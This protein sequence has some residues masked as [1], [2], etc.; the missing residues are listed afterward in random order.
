MNKWEYLGVEDLSQC[1]ELNLGFQVSS[2]DFSF[3]HGEGT[4]GVAPGYSQT[5]RSPTDW[6]YAVQS[7]RRQHH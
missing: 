5:P 1:C 2:S 6:F 3:R 7:H 4:Q